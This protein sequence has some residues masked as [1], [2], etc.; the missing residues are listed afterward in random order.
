LHLADRDA[1]GNGFNLG[2]QELFVAV[3]V[4]ISSPVLCKE[5]E[6]RPQVVVWQRPIPK[7]AGIAGLW[8]VASEPD[9]GTAASILGSPRIFTITQE[10]G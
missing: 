1:A 7:G 6:L 2:N 3:T 10:G 4:I 8:L 9:N 5:I